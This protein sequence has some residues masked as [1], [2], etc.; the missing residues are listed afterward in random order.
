VA[1]LGT[2]HVMFPK[3]QRRREHF[4][5]LSDLTNPVPVFATDK[6]RPRLRVQV[7]FFFF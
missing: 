2:R 5:G 7:V 3:L 1:E 6:R 4:L